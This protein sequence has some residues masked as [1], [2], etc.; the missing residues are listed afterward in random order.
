[1]LARIMSI[2][3]AIAI[4]STGCTEKKD[5]E[6]QSRSEEVIAD[7]DNSPRGATLPDDWRSVLSYG[8]HAHFAIVEGGI[9]ADGNALQTNIQSPGN[10]EFGDIKLAK[11]QIA[12]VPGV[13]HVLSLWAMGEPSA[14]LLIGLEDISDEPPLYRSYSVSP[15]WSK[16][17]VAFTPETDRVELSVNLSFAENI[18]STILL[19]K[20]SLTR[21]STNTI[22]FPDLEFDDPVDGHRQV[23]LG[24]VENKAKATFGVVEGSQGRNGKL[25]EVD[26][27][28]PSVGDQWNVQVVQHRIPIQPNVLYNYSA[29]VKGPRGAQT[30]FGVEG[31]VY[32]NIASKEVILVGDW[33]QVAFQ[34]I[35]QTAAV[36]L[37]IHFNYGFNE[38]AD[39]YIDDVRL[40]VSQ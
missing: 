40:E 39:I 33:Q 38:D 2:G 27:A 28:K 23:W 29:W 35:T 14:Q 5:E 15:E 32:Q 7:F 1:M 4:L 22:Y 34:F 19:D 17:D 13:E 31:P 18:G 8:A 36:R 20:I 16:F 21:A 30:Y 6:V 37:P 10:I 3:I 11:E 9:P 26:I 24:L 25:L 12:V